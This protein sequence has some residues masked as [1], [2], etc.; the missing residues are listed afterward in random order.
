MKV[1]AAANSS[2]S[3]QSRA[4][5]RSYLRV[6]S[7]F[8]VVLTVFA[9]A[10]GVTQKGE[11]YG[12]TDAKAQIFSWARDKGFRALETDTKLRQALAAAPYNYASSLWAADLPELQLDIK[13]R[14]LQK[15]YDKRQEAL[16]TGF[17]VQ[18]DDDFVPATLRQGE[19][20]VRVNLRLKGD[21]SDH[22]ETDK[23][24][25]RIRVRGGNALF[26]MRRFSVQHPATRGFQSELL[27]F[28]TV[29]RLGILA[30]RYFFVNL[31]VN[32]DAVGVMA[33]EEHFSKE[34]LEA[35]RR[36]EGVIVRYDESL[37]WRAQLAS[38]E[39]F[40][41]F[42]AATVDA[43]ASGKIAES[44]VLKAQMSVAVGLLRGF[45]EGQLTASQVFD[46][47]K[48][49]LY[50]AA[51][52]LWGAWHAMRWHNLRFYMNPITMKL[53]PIAFDADL[54][55][56]HHI[57]KAPAE[58]IFAR[59]EP[60]TRQMLSDE[61]VFRAYR[62]GI[63]LLSEQILDSS[64]VD[65]L[66]TI[67]RPVLPSLHEEFYLLEKYPYHELEERATFLQTRSD[68]QLLAPVEQPPEK[69]PEDRRDRFLN[70]VMAYRI[71][72]GQEPYLEVV[73]Q[74]RH[75]VVIDTIEWVDPLT[76]ETSQ[77]QI[78][79]EQIF[80]ITVPARPEKDD[81]AVGS[82]RIPYRGAED[83][84][85][86]T[87]K[88]VTRLTAENRSAVHQAIP[89]YPPLSRHPI[90]TSALADQIEKH[91]FLSLDADKK[92]LRVEPGEWHV[93]DP[94]IVPK[95]Y[96]LA[97]TGGTE[98]QFCEDCVIVSYGPLQI[99]GRQGEPVRFTGTTASGEN[100]GWR[101]IVVIDAE[102][103]SM[104]ENLIVSDTTGVS[105]S[106]WQLTGATTFYQSPVEIRNADFMRNQA[107]DALNI[108]LS[109]FALSEVDF[110]D[111]TSDALDVDFGSGTIIGGTFTDIGSAGGGDAVD[112]SGSE[113]LLKE[114]RFL[115]ISD[116][117]IS[118]GEASRMTAS[119][120][121]IEKAGTGAA[122]KDG[123]YLDISDSTMEH[124]QVAA[125][126]AYIKKPEYGSA[127]I[128]AKN[129]RLTDVSH[130]ARVQTGSSITVDG[131]EIPTEP[132]NVD[133]LYETAMKKGASL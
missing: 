47:K 111:T 133:L 81:A 26:G 44:P 87:I 125:L 127:G 70:H 59:A 113:V 4:A 52:E 32:G 98:L 128:T 109:E 118:V 123:S 79:S 28:E 73:N 82:I 67:E 46:A 93:E 2:G 15:I 16:T 94:L 105:M 108:F 102:G 86:K 60:I 89:Y 21:L 107:E 132:L 30:P 100:R 55:S 42:R 112:I 131:E 37:F 119:G 97:V 75:P 6:A 1:S 11:A 88:L 25:F 106:G 35:N 13:F 96:T 91:P 12:I 38:T 104:L 78:A 68:Q 80:P 43:F 8:A 3:R 10:Y 90:P 85:R 48:M 99:T 103:M 120:V 34:M 7:L 49:G 77:F 129:V 83:G 122:S 74:Q 14:H 71:D 69:I 50:L 101:G 62:D 84:D 33:L 124:I 116:K 95:G 27:F 65:E 64:L 56:R 121:T 19:K 114:T 53:E 54:Q 110:V 17:L 58:G 24:S 22:L 76:G 31:T 45:A 5:S 57:S 9:L 66:K 41:D 51:A 40:N 29:R 63:E 130:R 126:M 117:A 92:I 39:P 18:A 20:Q 36:R 72:A 115:D 23:W 61:A